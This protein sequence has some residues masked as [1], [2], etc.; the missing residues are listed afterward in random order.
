[1]MTYELYVLTVA[2]AWA[3]WEEW[4]ACSVSRSCETGSRSRQRTCVGADCPGDD[5]ETGSC[6]GAYP[7]RKYKHMFVTFCV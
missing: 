3:S 1:M 5:T 4:G 7:C 6:Q 2:A